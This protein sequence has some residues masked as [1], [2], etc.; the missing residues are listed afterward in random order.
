[1]VLWGIPKYLRADTIV[2]HFGKDAG[3]VVGIELPQENSK[4]KELRQKQADKQDSP[5]M[6]DKEI[7]RR[8]A[9][10]AVESGLGAE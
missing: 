9:I 3:A 7:S 8:K 6:L 2:E 5:Q 4:L 10:L 1:M